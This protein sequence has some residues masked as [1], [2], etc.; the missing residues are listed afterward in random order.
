MKRNSLN[1][2]F[3]LLAIAVM[4]GLTLPRLIQDGMFMDAMLYTSVAHNLSQGIGTFWF[5]QFSDY[6]IA[7][8]PAFHEQPPL[9]FGIQS[10]FFRLLGSSMYVE[11]FYTFMMMVI[12]AWLI[13]LFWENDLQR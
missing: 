9:F 7:G 4:T 1:T 6:H 13:V 2:P 3:W 8:L 5:P 11:R 10:S 12:T